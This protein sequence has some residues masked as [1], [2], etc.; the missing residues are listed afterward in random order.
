MSTAAGTPATS[1]DLSI[2]NSAANGQT[3]VAKDLIQQGANVDTADARGLTPVMLAVI[4]GHL[5][6]AVQLA[7]AGADLSRCDPDGRTALEY[8][9][10]AGNREVR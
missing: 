9:I 10:L 3:A 5:E 7:L 2:S 1:L 6:T 4:G 8:A